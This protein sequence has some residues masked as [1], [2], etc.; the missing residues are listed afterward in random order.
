MTPSAILSLLVLTACGTNSKRPEGTSAEAVAQGDR[1]TVTAPIMPNPSP[2]DSTVNQL[3]DGFERKDL[4][5]LSRL[6]SDS[7]S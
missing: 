3:A 6:V 4:D 1:A 2:T 5:A 7:Y